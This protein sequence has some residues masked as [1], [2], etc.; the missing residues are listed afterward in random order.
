[1]SATDIKFSDLEPDEEANLEIDDEKPIF[2]G[3]SDAM[4]TA[5][6]SVSRFASTK[7]SVI[8]TGETGVGKEVIAEA[9]HKSSPRKDKPF[10]AV[11]CGAF[12]G[13]LLQSELFGHEK[14][15]FTN[16]TSMRRGV[17]ELAN[18][19]T[20][21]LDEVG[22][23]SPKVQV[24]FLRVL[25]TQEFT[26]IGGEKTINVDVRIIAATNVDVQAAISEKKFRDDFYYRL[27]GVSIPIPPLR[28]RR[29][30]IPHFVEMFVSE[31]DKEYSQ[32][33]S[34]WKHFTHITEEALSSLKNYDWPGNVRELKD[35]IEL[36]IALNSEDQRLQLKHVEEGFEYKGITLQDP[37]P[38]KDPKI[39]SRKDSPKLFNEILG[40]LN[41]WNMQEDSPL[42]S[43]DTEIT[44]SREK[45]GCLAAYY[46]HQQ[47]TWIR[48]TQKELLEACDVNR[49]TYSKFK[50]EFEASPP[51]FRQNLIAR[52][53]EVAPLENSD[54]EENGSSDT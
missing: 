17:F 25:Q 11:N 52:I 38:I 37:L 10:K 2:F 6:K 5:M 47:P 4:Q 14:G 28:E 32:K 40:F 48:W 1:M 46:L 45:L 21:F 54:G 29:E 16:A 12:H 35:L 39:E 30:D 42:K 27:S 7:V 41:T 34:N 51:N 44:W 22:E 26:R 31:F 50:G 8:I 23:M 19:G 49:S 24:E 36:I 18:D 3:I 9:I 43:T 15:S 53:E 33:D 20:L 13:E